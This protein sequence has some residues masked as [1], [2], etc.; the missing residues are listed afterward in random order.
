[1]GFSKGSPIASI[2]TLWDRPMPRVSLP[3]QAWWA[4]AGVNYLKQ[5]SGSGIVMERSSSVRTAIFLLKGCANFHFP[6]FP[7]D[8]GEFDD[9]AVSDD[10]EG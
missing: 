9:L 3:W 10:L 6:E 2:M 8:S 7:L 4:L 5:Y 1:M